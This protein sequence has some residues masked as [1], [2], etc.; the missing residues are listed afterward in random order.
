MKQRTVGW[1]AWIVMCSLIAVLGVAAKRHEVAGGS[2]EFDR[3]V[4]SVTLTQPTDLRTV[5]EAIC[6]VSN[7]RCD[8]AESA[9]EV[10][11]PPLSLTGTWREVVAQLF[12]GAGHNYAALAPGGGEKGR[13]WVEARPTGSDPAPAIAGTKD[14]AGV[15]DAAYARPDGSSPQTSADLDRGRSEVDEDDGADG[16]QAGAGSSPAGG[17]VG[18]GGSGT[19]NTEQLRMTE[20]SLRMLYEGF[21]APR[22][23][24]PT[25]GMVTLPFVGP[26]GNFVTVPATNQPITVLP[27]PGPDGRMIT[28]TPT[29]GVQ[30][31]WPIPATHGTSNPPR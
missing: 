1:V 25:T 4:L 26:D 22:P 23:P 18:G 30:L 27:W 9:A 8:V 12:E 24:Q 21:G 2:V 7:S 11:L 29:P 20:Q 5:L 16:A 31:Q 6:L 15:D 28:V 17:G 14:R 10:E 3:G 13:L 19:P